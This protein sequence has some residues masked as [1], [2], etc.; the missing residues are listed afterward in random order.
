[1]KKNYRVFWLTF[2]LLLVAVTSIAQKKTMTWTTKS[3]KA[4]EL[5][6]VGVT[7]MLNIEFQQAYDHFK[8]ALSLD[9]DFTIALVFMTNL[10]TGN[11][12]KE[13][14]Q[15]ALKSAANKTEGEKLFASIVNPDRKPGDNRAVWTKLHEMFPDGGMLGAY[16]VISRETPEEQFSAAE[17]YIKKFPDNASMYNLVGYYYLSIKKDTAG[18][19][20]YFEK[21]VELYPDG[22]NPYDS[23]GEFYFITGDLANS[24]KYYNI[25][26]E[27]YPF[28]TS[29]IDKLKEI[30]AAKEKNAA[31]SKSSGN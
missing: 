26:L 24:E 17:D 23:M 3:E 9:P 21:Y 27:K 11:T 5:A 7:H 19:K 4:K 30:K 20:K 13:Y 22:S 15:K 29:S 2:I 18:A 31:N 1:M 16:Y 10:T 28:V 6:T 8:S 25:A 14:A 12:Q